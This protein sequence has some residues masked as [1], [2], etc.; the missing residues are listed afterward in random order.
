MWNQTWGSKQTFTKKQKSGVSWSHHT[1]LRWLTTSVPIKDYFI[2]KRTS[3][4]SCS[5]HSD[6]TCLK[7][8]FGQTRFDRD[9]PRGEWWP[10]SEHWGTDRK[11]VWLTDLLQG[12][13]E[14]L[15]TCCFYHILA[16]VLLN[17]EVLSL[18]WRSIKPLSN[19]WFFRKRNQSCCKQWQDVRMN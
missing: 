7:S 4:G 2:H 8:W 15:Q 11:T 17:Y 14:N 18:V 19:K 6:P 12:H 16:T 5:A 10:G 3:E 1:K 13:V 9:P